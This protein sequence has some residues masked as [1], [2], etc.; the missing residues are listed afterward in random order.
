[1]RLKRSLLVLIFFL[2]IGTNA[3][4]IDD[5]REFQREAWLPKLDSL[6]QAV[7]NNKTFLP[8]YEL[9]ALIALAHYPEL[10]DA[11][12]E[13]VQQKIS[14]NLAA[15]PKGFSVFR[16][17]GKRQYRVFVNFPESSRVPLD[18]VSFNGQIGVIAHELAHLAYYETKRTPRI[19]LDGLWYWNLKFRARF[20][21][22]TDQRTIEHGLGWQLYDFSSFV[23]NYVTDDPEYV[24][25]KRRIYLTPEDIMQ[26]LAKRSN[27]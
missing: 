27:S 3:W 15:R 9:Q 4:S 18:S 10:K 11:K 19:L 2:G 22:D 14:S 21:H 6:R 26:L 24:A 16:R 13:F 7:G 25:Y 17:K 12:I 5:V 23:L 8:Q 1:M 20:E